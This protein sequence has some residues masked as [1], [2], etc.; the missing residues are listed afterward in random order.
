M[1]TNRGLN[2]NRKH[3]RYMAKPD[4]RAFIPDFLLE[5]PVT[6]VSEGGLGIHHLNW[7]EFQKK[8]YKVNLRNK[9]RG[10]GTLDVDV[11]HKNVQKAG[12][13]FMNFSEDQLYVIEQL[14]Q[15]H[16]ENVLY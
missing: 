15:K 1:T 4:L 6:D 7:P 8:A 12:C 10:I 2:N 16:T 9:G 11:V 14:V 5:F 3:H 13:S